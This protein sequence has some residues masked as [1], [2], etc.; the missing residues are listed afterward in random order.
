MIPFIKNTGWILIL[1][2]CLIACDKNDPGNGN[3]DN[4]LVFNSLTCGRDTIF[5]EDT[6]R[7][8]ASASGDELIFEWFVEK[9]D[10]LGSGAE[11]TFVATPCTIGNN[12]IHCTVKDVHGKSET[13]F[14]TVTVL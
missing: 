6:T 10:L 12:D 2:C 5:T 13:R 1:A 3:S 7:I 4:P 14:V 9:G 8:R 11:I